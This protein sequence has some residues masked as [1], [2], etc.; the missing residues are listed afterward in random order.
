MGRDACCQKYQYRAKHNHLYRTAFFH[1]LTSPFPIKVVT[2]TAEQSCFLR[3][4][5]IVQP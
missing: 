4:R 3:L 5:I 1:F 2:L